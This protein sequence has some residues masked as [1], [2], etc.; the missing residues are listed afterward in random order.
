MSEI[1]SNNQKKIIFANTLQE[2]SKWKNIAKWDN[3]WVEDSA[4]YSVFPMLLLKASIHACI[5][6]RE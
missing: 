4:Q 1:Y 3:E 5:Q 2:I 6:K